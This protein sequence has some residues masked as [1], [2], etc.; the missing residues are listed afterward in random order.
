MYV[1]R[2][3]A[4]VSGSNGHKATFVVAV[5]LIKGFKLTVAEA[6]PIM[7]DFNARCEPPWRDDELEYKL[8]SADKSP[9]KEP[10]GNLLDGDEDKPRPSSAPTTSEDETPRY[11]PPPKAEFDRAALEKFAG[12]Y[13]AVVDLKW[14]ANRSEIDPAMVDSGRFLRTIFGRGEKVLVFTND[15]TQGEAL[16]PGEALPATGKLGVWFLC[17]P[18][19]GEYHPN[20]RA[21]RN[22]DGTCKMSRRSEES[23]TSWRHM[24]LESDEAPTRLWLGAI[25]QL[26]LR[27][28]ALYTSGSR[29]VHALIDV[30]ATTK[31]EWD[32]EKHAIKAGLLT[33]GADEG[34]LSAVRLTRLPGA[35]REGKIVK[36]PTGRTLPTGAEEMRERYVR[37]DAPKPQ[38]L[39]YINSKP[40]LRPLADLL[41]IRNVE[42]DWERFAK[43]APADS[44][45]TGGK[46]RTHG[47]T[48][49]AN[50]SLRLRELLARMNAEDSE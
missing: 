21:K 7:R 31:A 29:S 12:E 28:A 3:P 33:L 15:K 36:E 40:Q 6:L 25:A 22:P 49:Y 23:V 5:A 41:P 18:V 37:F 48:Y 24:V 17:Q 45:E 27:I 14:L 2:M 8:N 44:D 43:T 16:W 42:K 19:D 9:D 26:K 39:L 46:W 32:A 13:A 47:L 34:A 20:P 35:M 10:R 4:A 38:K 1:A 50:V 11:V 30:K